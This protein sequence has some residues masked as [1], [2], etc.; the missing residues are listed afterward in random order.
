LVDR[1]RKG[2]EQINC[3]VWTMSDRSKKNKKNK[4]K[5]KPP[6]TISYSCL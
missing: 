4:N 1:R 6:P 3:W 2:V 5:N